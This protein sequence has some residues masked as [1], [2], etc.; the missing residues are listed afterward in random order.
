V[1]RLSFISIN[2]IPGTSWIP[3][4]GLSTE[5]SGS[6]LPQPKRKWSLVNKLRSNSSGET[7]SPTMTHAAPP[8][9]VNRVILCKDDSA[10]TRTRRESRENLCGSASSLE[11]VSENSSL[12]DAQKSS[13]RF[14]IPS[15]LPKSIPTFHMEI[16]T[17][18]ETLTSS[19]LRRLFFSTFLEFRLGDDERKLW[20]SLTKFQADFGSLTDVEVAQHQKDIRGA[21]QKILTEYP[22]IPNHDILV[23]A[24]KDSSFHASS[25][26]F[27]DAEVK[28]YAIFHNSYQSYL[29]NNQWVR[30]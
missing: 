10:Q 22:L 21:A 24:I 6:S 23:K 16:P 30:V 1:Q 4:V 25:R 9:P 8:S 5:M 3:S 14:R 7:P 11:D 2:A 18:T 12:G 20:D 17:L 13:S 19:H 27:L 29:S 15:S 26:F 28:L